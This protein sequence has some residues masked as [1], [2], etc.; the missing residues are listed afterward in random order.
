MKRT[1]SDVMT[2]AV[3]SVDA[4]TPFKE[5][6]QRMQEHR[7]SALPVVDEDG[8]VLGLVSEA[9]LMLKEDPDLEGGARVFEGAHRRRDR[10]RAAG[11]V[12]ADLMNAPAITITPGASIGDAARLMH[13]RE[14]KR[15]PVVDP[16]DGR[17][18]GI[19]A[20]ADVLKV[21]L[22]AD[23]EIAREIRED[24]IRR[25]LWIDPATIRV[26]VRTGI[27][28]AEGQLERRS[29]IAVLERLVLATEGV[30]AFEDHLSYLTDDVTPPFD[31]SSSWPTPFSRAGR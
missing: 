30:V 13:R 6:V 14:V 7:V 1:V 2:R 23:E 31:V 19:V 15:L 28:S 17:I 22:R 21:F 24:V 16:T 20:R 27:V 29:L 4:F 18:V 25:T 10:S 12:A 26:V 5:I 9:D 11:L 3:V 8:C